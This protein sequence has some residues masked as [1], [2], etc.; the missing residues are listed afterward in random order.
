MSSIDVSVG[1]PATT[2]R[3]SQAGTFAVVAAL[4]V[5]FMAAAGAP[6]PLYVVYQKNWGFSAT[7]LTVV[8]AVYVAGLLASLLVVGGLSDHVGRRPV[9][10]AAI[11][12][13]A[14]SFVLFLVAGGVPMLLVARVLQG[15]ATGAAITT[16]SAALVDSVPAHRPGRAGVV[17]SVAPVSGLAVGA[18]GAGA[19]VE[20]APAPTHLVYAVFLALFVLGGIAVAAMP[21]TSA[22][23]S[24]AVGSLR[25]ALAVPARI[26]IEVLA[27]VPILLASWSLGG[28][29]FSL[30]P[31]VAADVL[32]LHNHLVGGLVVGLLCVPGALTSLLLRSWPVERLVVVAALLLAVGTASAV[33]GVDAGP[34]VLGVV[35]TV[36]AGIGFGAAALGTFG[37]YARIAAPHERGALFAVAYTIS[38][39]AF[40][41]PAVAAGLATTAVGLR[42]TTVGYGIVVVA[43]GIVALVAQ[44]L[45]AARRR[46]AARPALS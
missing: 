5:L 32:G 1:P 44:W 17:N 8:F 23:R 10:A 33:V 25:P 15:L 31:S 14:T 12:L 2:A 24:G 11:A 26:R 19:L 36:V 22:R 18:L 30:G 39:L 3:L 38:Y 16:L 42:P 6:T 34:A 4:V 29:F 13:E 46:A 41:V 27:L 7:T 45:V 37:T 21:E 20:Y 43:L 9:L 28:L 40:S 35:G